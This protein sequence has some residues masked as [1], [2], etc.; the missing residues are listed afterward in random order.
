MLLGRRWDKREGKGGGG[1]GG[2]FPLWK[3][4]VKISQLT[5]LTFKYRFHAKE[6]AT[7]VFLLKLC[8]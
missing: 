3:V 6:K 2:D 4:F 1:A 5:Y 8:I 7:N